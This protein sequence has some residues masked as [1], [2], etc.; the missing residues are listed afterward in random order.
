MM[1]LPR[2][3]FVLTLDPHL[4]RPSRTQA[5]LAFRSHFSILAEEVIEIS[6]ADACFWHLADISQPSTDVRTRGRANKCRPDEY[7][8]QIEHETEFGRPGEDH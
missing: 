4:C 7:A 3:S 8:T 2:S 5:A 6:R 1:H